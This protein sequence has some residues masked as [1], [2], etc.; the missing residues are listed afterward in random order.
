[1]VRRG[2]IMARQ[3]SMATRKE[4]I[5]AVG[6]RYRAAGRVERGKILDEFTN[7]TGF[8]RKHAVRVLANEP[9]DRPPKRCRARLYGQPVKEAL[10]LVWEA[11][12]RVC[13]KRLK[14]L[15]PTLVGAM[16]RHGRSTFDAEVKEALLRMSAASIDRLLREVREEAGGQRKRRPG[17]GS[18]IRRAVRVRTFSDWNDPPPGFFETDMVE[19]CW[20]S[21]VRR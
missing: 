5:A 11:A 21:E 18:A 1:M 4:L 2:R 19:H 3:I 14:A 9:R 13:G 16:E 8:H 10:I 6:I 12:D 15:I 20:R 17:V 7:L